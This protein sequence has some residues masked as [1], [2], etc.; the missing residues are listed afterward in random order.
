MT[1]EQE[2]EIRVYC[3]AANPAYIGKKLLAELDAERAAHEETKAAWKAALDAHRDRETETK[4]ECMRKLDAIKA[5]LALAEAVC[6]EMGKG[7]P[8]GN[9]GKALAAWRAGE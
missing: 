2:R 9:V 6:A 5:R 4:L 3:E 1:D 8:T 7:T